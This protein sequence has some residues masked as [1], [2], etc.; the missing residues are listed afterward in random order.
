MTD[1]LASRHAGPIETVGAKLGLPPTALYRYGPLKAKVDLRAVA[2]I[3]RTK[4]G[5]LIL[6]TATSPTETGEGKTTTSI[7]LADAFARLNHK[8]ALCLREPSL[9]PCFGRKGGA[10]GSGKAAL[11]PAEDIN[12]HFT[13][14]LHAIT[15]ANNLLA[16]LVDNQLYWDNELD[17]DPNR[18]TWRRAIDINDRA[19][20]HMVVGLGGGDGPLHEAGFDITAASETMGVFCLARSLTDLQNRL[21]AMVVGR[22]RTG[23]LILAESLRAAP[24]MTALLRDAFSPNLVQTLEG[25]PA[26]VHG[27]PF[28]NIAHGCSSLVS[29]ETSLHLADI[30]ITEAGFGADLGAEKFIDILGRTSGIFPDAVVLV[31]TV[32]ALKAQSAEATVA[33]G[34]PNLLL[35]LSNLAHFNVPVV[36]A[37]NVFADDTAEDIHAIQAVCQERGV[38]ALP[39]RHWAEG[40]AGA[41]GLAEALLPLLQGPKPE[42]RLLYPDTLP[43][44]GKIEE[45]ATRIYRAG[46]VT[47]TPEALRHLAQYEGE[48]FGH[49][50]VCIAKTPYSFSAN[51]ERRGAPEGHTFPVRDVRLAAGAGFVV[52]L[53]GPIFTMPGLPREPAASRVRIGPLG[54]IEGLA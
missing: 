54:A 30:T 26:F 31:T 4:P 12:L 43:L 37:I 47:F 13:G 7:G 53:G 38:T 28:A 6:V 8:V 16:A 19:L 22:S 42:V 41:V 20:R 44:A 52:A 48:G 49:L 29:L 50:P 24:A 51:P 17:L 46:H 40:G 15:S 21:G 35:H 3:A 5:K 36:V 33:A 11:T 27:G 10:T 14:D 18:I 32:K 9:G 45:V 1:D 39:A 23:R 2:K 25:T 34:V